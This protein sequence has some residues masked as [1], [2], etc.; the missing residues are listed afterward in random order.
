MTEQSEFM[1]G[2]IEGF[3]G[4][5]WTQG[6]RFELFG[7][8][9]RWGLNTYFYGPKDD[10]KHR[11]IWRE[12]YTNPETEWLGSVIQECATHGIRFIYGIGPGLDIR[13]SNPVDIELLQLRL[14]QLLSL[15]C[16]NFAILFDDI[17]DGMDADDAKRFGS[18]ASAQCHVT[19]ALLLRMRERCPQVKFYF[20]PTP[21][22]GRMVAAG[23]GGEGYL[24]T[25]GEHLDSE[26]EIFWTGPEIISQEITVSHILEMQRLFR[27]KPL[28]WD[29]LHANDY[30]GRRF[31]CGPYSG[32]SPELRNLVS[33]ILS[34]PNNEFPLNYVPLCTLAMFVHNTGY[35]DARAA[36]LAAMKDWLPQFTTLHHSIPLDDL[37]LLGDCYYLPQEE[38]FHAEALYQ[39]VETV[40]DPSAADWMVHVHHF[41]EQSSRLKTLCFRLT[42][43][44]HRRLFYALSR[45]IWELREEL[46]FLE[47][48]VAFLTTRKDPKELFHP[49]VHLAGT[50]RGGIV[51]RLQRLLNRQVDGT[52]QATSPV[53]SVS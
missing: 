36:Y 3:Y 35:W 29:N 24:E 26:I 20:C 13:Y 47:R 22:C 45:R 48:Y 12:C 7:Q 27:R 1:S 11:A 40:L 41:R 53:S 33:G 42:E 19:N 52:F 6:E 51:P 30:D 5:P 25:L 2:V 38:G 43:L 15:G 50:Y 32:R 37:V 49:E 44:R 14:E 18:F 31:F 39:T 21:Y 23:L 9:S 28:I 46:D 16:Q 10:L 34:N 8:M 4:E 17:P